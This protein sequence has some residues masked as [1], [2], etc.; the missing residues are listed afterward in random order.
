MN[1]LAN[2]FPLVVALAGCDLINA[3]T[4]DHPSTKQTN[5][6]GDV[7][8]SIGAFVA[9]VKDPASAT[10]SDLADMHSTAPY[11]A[12]LDP[13][14]PAARQAR[15]ADAPLDARCF[16][17]AGSSATWD[18]S[19]P[20]KGVPCT[21]KGN[22]TFDRAAGT[23]SGTSTQTCE[24]SPAITVTATKVAFDEKLGKGS[25]TFDVT[26]FAHVTVDSIGFCTNEATPKPNT[27]S[28]TVD[29]L[30]P[31]EGLPFDPIKISFS[32]VPECGAP[33]IE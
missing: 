21:A 9:V 10:A 24:G 17:V 25:G 23:A 11:R 3:A 5:S 8:G 4:A 22:G 1:K 30:G 15:D 33:T 14:G 26:G 18:C 7:F 28:V 29:G 13:D 19:Y 12:L 20:V 2:L 31:L 6:L 16:T 32:D 27:G